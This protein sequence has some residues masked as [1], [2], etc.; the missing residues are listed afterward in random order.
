MS[1]SLEHISP[2]VL[3]SYVKINFIMTAIFQSDVEQNMLQIDHSQKVPNIS[4][5]NLVMS[6]WIVKEVLV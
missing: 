5:L 3:L 2:S 4:Y 6:Y 1:L